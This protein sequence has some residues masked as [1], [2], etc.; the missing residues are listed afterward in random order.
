MPCALWIAFGEKSCE[1]LQQPDIVASRCLSASYCC[2]W[3][4]VKTT[5]AR[6][7]LVQKQYNFT[8]VK[9]Y[10]FVWFSLWDYWEG[11]VVWFS[12]SDVINCPGSR[13]RR[14]VCEAWGWFQELFSSWIKSIT[15]KHVITRSK[16][17]F[18]FSEVRK[19]LSTIC[20]IRNADFCPWSTSASNL[21]A[22]NSQRDF[23]LNSAFT[24]IIVII[25][26][27]YHDH[28][29]HHHH[30]EPH[31]HTRLG[32]AGTFQSQRRRH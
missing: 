30:N 11:A 25:I 5:R 21:T 7:Q 10:G 2:N 9:L 20:L 24:M 6:L 29:Y 17:Y 27:I 14:L 13:S 31:H 12:E 3:C 16:S 19:V 32:I 23:C 28:H 18:T 22:G 15:S 1:D 4:L 8:I 26:V